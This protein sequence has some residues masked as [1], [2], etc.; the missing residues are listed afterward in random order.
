M[1]E[2][3]TTNVNADA[4]RI[5]QHFIAGSDTVR[6]MIEADY[7]DVITDHVRA[8][9]HEYRPGPQRTWTRIGADFTTPSRPSDVL[10]AIGT[11][12]RRI[13]AGCRPLPVFQ[14]SAI[15]G[16]ARGYGL[17]ALSAL[18]LSGLHSSLIWQGDNYAVYG[19]EAEY[20]NGRARL[21]L[22]DR[23]TMLVPLASECWARSQRSA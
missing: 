18:A 17:P 12:R 7:P 11:L 13:V 19:I 23:G 9:A 16:A 10:R 14:A 21:Y 3:K 15:V 4:R 1:A 8:R 5:V 6:D 22:L 20:P 2:S